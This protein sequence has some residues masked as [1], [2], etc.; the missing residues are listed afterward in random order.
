MRPQDVAILLKIIALG[1]SE[2]QLA[3]LSHSLKISLSEISESLNR[4]RTANLLSANKKTVH[5]QNFLEFLQYGVKYVFPVQPGSLVQGIP[6]AHAHPSVQN[7][8]ISNINY[9]WPHTNGTSLGLALTPFYPGQAEAVQTD[10]FFYELLALVDMI[11]AGR[12]RE[13]EYAVPKLEEHFL[14]HPSLL[15]AHT[16]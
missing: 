15:Q 5:R 13:V 8:F 9:V 11:R 1:E 7:K 10:G 3:T 14:Q 4:S 6:T 16:T 12:V 2:W